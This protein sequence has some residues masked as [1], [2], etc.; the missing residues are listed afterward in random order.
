[1]AKKMDGI[2]QWIRDQGGT[3]LI[4]KKEDADSVSRTLLGSGCIVYL[5]DEPE[6]PK[7]VFYVLD[8]NAA[9]RLAGS[10]VTVREPDVRAWAEAFV[11][12]KE[13]LGWKDGKRCDIYCLL[14]SPRLQAFLPDAFGRRSDQRTI[15]YPITIEH[16]NSSSNHGLIDSVPRRLPVSEYRSAR[17]RQTP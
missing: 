10:K 7:A 16:S 12:H 1:M 3:I 5:E 4:A 17:Y 2:G 6:Y 13:S 8:R 9:E 15:D 14:R 11:K